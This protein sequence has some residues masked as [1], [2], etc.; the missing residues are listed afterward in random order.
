MRTAALQ[1]HIV[2]HR[3]TSTSAALVVSAPRE[4]TRT[5]AALIACY[6]APCAAFHAM[7]VPMA[8]SAVRSIKM[9]AWEEVPPE[10]AWAKNAWDAMGLTSSSLNQGDE[11]VVVPDN[12][13][14]D[15]MRSW[16]FCSTA[17]AYSDSGVDCYDLPMQ[18]AGRNVYICSMPRG[19]RPGY[20]DD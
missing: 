10:L 4:P 2:R 16:F 14:P 18:T 20:A 11:C 8:R 3:P 15:P 19:A 6:L 17:G 1:L 13:A 5:V 12:F 9:V 7:P